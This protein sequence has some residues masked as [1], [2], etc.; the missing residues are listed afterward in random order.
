MQTPEAV[1][2]KRRV[3]VGAL[4]MCLEHSKV[5]ELVAVDTIRSILESASQ[6]LWREGEFRLELVW[7]ILCQQPGLSAEDVAPPLLVFKAY[8]SQLKVQVRL[9]EA[10]SALPPRERERLRETIP[11]PEKDFAAAIDEMRALAVEEEAPRSQLGQVA[12]AAVTTEARPQAAVPRRRR[13]L[14]VALALLALPALGVSAW[15]AFRNPASAYEL[16]DV[17]SLLQLSDGLRTEQSMSAR[18]VDPR[19]DRL[20][21][22]EQRK[23]V[24]E[25]FER[26]ERKGV[27]AMT[28]VDAQS[29]VRV[30]ATDIGAGLQ[31]T[32]Y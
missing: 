25:L 31:V 4:T 6:E 13:Q 7:K 26:E 12:Q 22:D 1:G 19:W 23:I 16:G 17:A 28:L 14:A 20:G 32:V 30:V 18:I 10:L 11:I 27:R 2:A 8:E 3:L 15:V 5:R 9:P 24:S 21:K 29:R